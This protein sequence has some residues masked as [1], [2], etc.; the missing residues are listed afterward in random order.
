VLPA[1]TTDEDA[2]PLLRET[3]RRMEAALRRLARPGHQRRR[4][5]HAPDAG[6]ED[7]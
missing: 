3:R 6:A 7:L 5:S 4:P 1:G 2:V